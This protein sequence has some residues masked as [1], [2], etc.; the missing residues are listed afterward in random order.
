MK[1]IYEDVHHLLTAM[2]KELFDCLEKNL[3][4]HLCISCNK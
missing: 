1:I 2:P 3:G 4:W